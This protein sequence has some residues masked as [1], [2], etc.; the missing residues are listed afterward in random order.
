[1]GERVLL[2]D[3]RAI[4]DGEE[5][6]LRHVQRRAQV[7][8]IGDHVVGGVEAPVVAE[9]PR[10]RLQGGRLR[11]QVVGHGRLQCVARQRGRARPALV[12]QD[13]A[14]GRGDL[15]AELCEQRRRGRHCGSARPAAEQQQDAA[16]RGPV[17]LDGDLQ[18]QPEGVGCARSSGTEKVAQVNVVW[19][20]NAAVNPGP[21]EDGVAVG[22][23]GLTAVLRGVGLGRGPASEPPLHAVASMA[24]TATTVV[25]RPPADRVIRPAATFAPQRPQRLG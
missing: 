7:V 21:S 9:G 18:R 13:D 11:R 17:G 16:G 6:E 12:D 4:A 1:M 10:A 25:R 14:I 3:E 20:G 23:G 19:Q 22:A 15:G 5:G 2:R 8:E 24:S